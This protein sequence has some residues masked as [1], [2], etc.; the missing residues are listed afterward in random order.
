MPFNYDSDTMK[1]RAA[2]EIATGVIGL[3]AI[4]A[5]AFWQ[6]PYW[7]GGA[8]GAVA[9]GFLIRWVWKRHQKKKFEQIADGEN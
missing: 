2:I 7:T 9:A 8:V 5:F 6:K 1:L 4:L 3:L